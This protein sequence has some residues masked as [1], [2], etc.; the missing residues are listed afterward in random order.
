[1]VTAGGVHGI[2]GLSVVATSLE[3]DT[4]SIM[5]PSWMAISAMVGTQYT[6]VIAINV[7]IIDFVRDRGVVVKDLGAVG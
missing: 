6:V 2:D 1:L 5:I 4:G 3:N 7:D